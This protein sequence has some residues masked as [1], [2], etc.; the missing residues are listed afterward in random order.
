MTLATIDMELARAALGRSPLF[1][2][3][4][5]GDVDRCCS[6]LRHRHFRRGEAIFHAGDPGDT[7][8]VIA[9]GAVLVQLPAPDGSAPAVLATLRPGDAFGELALLDGAP[10][11]ATVV[12]LEA[13][14]TLVLHRDAFLRLVEESPTLRVS[15]LAALTTELRRLTGHVEELHFL[16]LG[17]RLAG[18]LLEAAAAGA[19]GQERDIRLSWPYTQADL[20][21]M[22]GGSRESVNRLLGELAHRGVVRVERDLLVIPDLAAL[23][24]EARP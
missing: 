9:S 15:L 23:E 18:R 24:A 21:G 16:G 5:I 6:L 7:L 13:T 4:D 2:R 3:L 10:R 19:P 1:R 22:I 11:S 12:A 14:E 8:H 17:Q 20:A